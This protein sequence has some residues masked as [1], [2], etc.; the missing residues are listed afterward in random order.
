MKQ[1]GYYATLTHRFTPS[2]LVTDQG[3]FILRQFAGSTL[4]SL[5]LE[6]VLK[7]TNEGLK[8][9]FE[10][11]QEGA[12]EWG[13]VPS[14]R[15]IVLSNMGEGV[16]CNDVFRLL[17]E[18]ANAKGDGDGL[19]YCDFSGAGKGITDKAMEHLAKHSKNR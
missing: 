12:M 7:I 14:L 16:V 13:K 15:R 5:E 18:A 17:C 2:R 1:L 19:D 6:E 3:I 9:F 10:P 4:R 8:V 11:G